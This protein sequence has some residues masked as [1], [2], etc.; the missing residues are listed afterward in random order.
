MPILLPFSAGAPDQLI[1]W[2][3]SE[4]Q[5]RMAADVGSDLALHVAVKE[6]MAG[7][8][9]VFLTHT[10]NQALAIVNR[11]R[12]LFPEVMFPGVDFT[13]LQLYSH[14]GGSLQLV[15]EGDSQRIRDLRG[16]AVD[17]VFWL[18]AS[19][20]YRIVSR[21]EYFSQ[22]ASHCPEGLGTVYNNYIESDKYIESDC[23]KPVSRFS[24]ILSSE[25]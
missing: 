8:A 13:T 22:H 25:F 7:R 5:A 2:F 1:S 24:R 19:S 6:A 11:L 3:S 23:P 16:Q 12:A 15:A 10:H 18:T 9:V 14:S 20:V 4:Q 21:E 17:S